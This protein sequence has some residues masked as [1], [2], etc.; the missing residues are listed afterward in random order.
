MYKCEICS[1]D[2]MAI[3]GPSEHVYVICGA[4]IE[5]SR[6]IDGTLKSAFDKVKKIRSENGIKY[7]Q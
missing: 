5:E 1:A 3:Y 4:C 2:V 6:R 7:G